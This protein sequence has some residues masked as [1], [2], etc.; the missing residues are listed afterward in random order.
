M[1]LLLFITSV[2]MTIPPISNHGN[3]APSIM[4]FTPANDA[5]LIYR[6]TEFN[7]TAVANGWEGNGTES[8]PFIISGYSLDVTNTS[9]IEIRE[10]T[11]YG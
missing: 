11:V 7:D 6:D 3:I 2:G 9:A 8:N 1:I 5:I 4:N 10:T